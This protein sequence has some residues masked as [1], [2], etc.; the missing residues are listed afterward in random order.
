MPPLPEDEYEGLSPSSSEIGD[1]VDKG[2]ESLFGGQ[3]ELK[4]GSTSRIVDSDPFDRPPGAG[5]GNKF[6]EKGILNSVEVS[7]A[8]LSGN[9]I[10]SES[11]FIPPGS[12][13]A[14]PTSLTPPSLVSLSP[15]PPPSTQNI[16]PS[17]FNSSL[18]PG[19]EIAADFEK[20]PLW[21]E[22]LLDE[23]WSEADDEPAYPSLVAE[24]TIPS[25]S[26]APASSSGGSSDASS[27][28]DWKELPRKWSSFLEAFA[29]ERPFTAGPFQGSRIRLSEEEVGVAWLKFASRGAYALVSGDAEMRKAVTQSLVLRL[30][31]GFSFTLRWEAPSP[32]EEIK[33]ESLTN[34]IV[35]EGGPREEAVVAYILRKFKGQSLE[36]RK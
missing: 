25:P 19:S 18:D 12:A 7:P 9:S 34:P 13:S 10:E 22:P 1:R 14:T 21:E 29:A 32:E 16:P 6:L 2:V 23:D 33:S 31:E 28:W 5:S 35:E 36:H 15:T 3:K 8:A 26:T 4:A 11:D 27:R 20:D 30:P 24:P 17:D